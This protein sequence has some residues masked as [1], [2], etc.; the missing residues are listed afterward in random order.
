MN[1]LWKLALLVLICEGVGILGSYFTISQIPT[2]YATLQ[3]PSFS[4]PN[5]I[6]APVWTTL[7]FSMGL[8]L[9][10]VLE[11]KLKKDKNKIIMLFS[12][13]LL[14]NF[15]W[16]F[17]FFG[18]HSPILAFIDIAMLWGS[19]IFLIYEFWRHSKA[20]SLLLIPYLLWVS[21]ASILN[22]FII[23]LNK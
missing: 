19:I 12:L 11:K 2:W 6:F 16:S 13:S 5:Y 9:F 8:S 18:L 15:I 20:A 21:F 23:V 22:L 1:K 3:K 7:Y 14:F 4:P 17:V 10:L